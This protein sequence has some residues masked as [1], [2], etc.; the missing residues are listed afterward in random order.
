MNFGFLQLRVLREIGV[1]TGDR[2]SFEVQLW[3]GP[4]YAG[5]AL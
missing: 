1:G 3:A 5:L 2:E 4:H